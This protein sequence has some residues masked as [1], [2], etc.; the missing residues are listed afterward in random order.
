MMN[1]IY[2]RNWQTPDKRKPSSL[3]PKLEPVHSRRF[4]FA[5]M[6]RTPLGIGYYGGNQRSSKGGW[7]IRVRWDER[8][9]SFGYKDFPLEDIKPIYRLPS[10]KTLQLLWRKQGHMKSKPKKPPTFIVKMEEA[11]KIRPAVGSRV[12]HLTHGPGT[13]QDVT[14]TLTDWYAEVRFDAS[15]F[16][17]VEHVHEYNSKVFYGPLFEN[18]APE[19]KR[20]MVIVRNVR[21][22][23][24]TA[25]MG[26][27]VRALEEARARADRDA[28]E[29]YV[30]A[31]GKLARRSTRAKNTDVIKERATLTN[32]K[33]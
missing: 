12:V 18:V 32:E 33:P 17:P 19:A 27:S 10:G 7:I 23:Y 1:G 24:P 30:G 3:N 5:Q 20:K 26:A 4:G 15:P 25:D 9:A 14:G 16:G 13:V 8:D 21:E 31:N 6:W 2:R 22:K 29:F 11:E 28:T